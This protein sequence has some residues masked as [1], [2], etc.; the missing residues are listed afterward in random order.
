MRL[1]MSITMLAVALFAT[2]GL[3]SADGEKT[4]QGARRGRGKGHEKHRSGEDGA[5]SRDSKFRAWDRDGNGS[6]SPGEY[7]GHPGNFRALDTDNSGGLTIDEFQHRAGVGAPAGS[8]RMPD[9]TPAERDEDFGRLDADND[10][11]IARQEWRGRRSS[12]D[13]LDGDGN[14]L[15][16]RDE[17]RRRSTRSRPN[18]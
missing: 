11:S 7:P 1:K 8:A 13:A 10:G 12:F 16:T 3:V 18:R 4:E 17:Y 9:A 6:I 5:A 14:G 15:V 2:A